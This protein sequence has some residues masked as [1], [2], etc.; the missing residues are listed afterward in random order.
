MNKTLMKNNSMLKLFTSNNI[1][2]RVNLT[3]YLTNKCELIWF[4]G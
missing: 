4:G 3:N 2:I 1:M